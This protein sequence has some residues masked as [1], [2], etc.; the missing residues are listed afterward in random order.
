MCFL[1][2]QESVPVVKTVPHQR[3]P[4]Q[5]STQSGPKLQQGIYTPKLVTERQ[6]R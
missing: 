4:N 2:R 1:Q 5:A 6:V 3:F